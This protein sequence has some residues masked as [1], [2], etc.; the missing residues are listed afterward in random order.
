M[1]SPATECESYNNFMQTLSAQPVDVPLLQANLADIRLAALR[2]VP[3][4]AIVLMDAEADT[5]MDGN[6]IS[7]VVS[8]YGVPGRS[9]VTED[10]MRSF[11]VWG[12]KSQLL[13]LF[14]DLQLRD[15]MIY[16][17]TVSEETIARLKAVAAGNVNSLD[18][19]Y[20][21]CFITGNAISGGNNNFVMEHVALTSNSFEREGEAEVGVVISGAAI[22]VGNFAPGDLRLFNATPNNQKAANLRLV[23][24]TCK[25]GEATRQTVGSDRLG[26]TVFPRSK[27]AVQ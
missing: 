17:I 18:R 6:K 14:V 23:S 11:L 2:A 7:G 27:E 26:V 8:L 25:S 19:L 22:Y 24:W 5:G 10:E 4:T 1:R 15:N 16:R 21:R 3:G 13:R 9:Q 20:R 12:G